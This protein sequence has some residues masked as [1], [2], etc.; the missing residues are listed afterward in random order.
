MNEY[1]KKLCASMGYLTAQGEDGP[2]LLGRKLAALN[3]LDGR[4]RPLARTFIKSLPHGDEIV[5]HET[6]ARDRDMDIDKSRHR[7]F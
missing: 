1:G 2:I 6:A 3:G 5:K 7:A 4:E